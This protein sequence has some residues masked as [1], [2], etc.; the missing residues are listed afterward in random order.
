MVSHKKYFCFRIFSFYSHSGNSFCVWHNQLS[1]C[2][3]FFILP[4]T[5]ESCSEFLLTCNQ[6]LF[7]CLPLHFRF[8][9][10]LKHFSLFRCKWISRASQNK[11][12]ASSVRSV[13][14]PRYAF[15]LASALNGTNSKMKH[16]NKS[17]RTYSLWLHVDV[18]WLW[19]RFIRE[20]KNKSRLCWSFV[21]IWLIYLELIVWRNSSDF[22]PTLTLQTANDM[23]VASVT[24][25]C[26]LILLLLFYSLLLATKIYSIEKFIHWLANES[27]VA[28]FQVFNCVLD[29]GFSFMMQCAFF[30]FNLRLRYISAMYFD[31][32]NWK[33]QKRIK[34]SR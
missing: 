4:K 8:Y 23:R 10:E 22:L 19:I 1:F 16:I 11:A 9:V 26:A 15:A 13:Q 25:R 20:L 17:Q 28:G 33:K 14:C 24:M 34:H 12:K 31:G 6:F 27:I 18:R 3:R 30:C 7:V 5:W 2:K 29:V 21:S 32:D